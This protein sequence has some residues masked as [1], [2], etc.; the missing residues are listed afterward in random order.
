[1]LGV[2]SRLVDQIHKAWSAGGG[3]RKERRWNKTLATT[4]GILDLIQDLAEQC[5]E[6]G[7]G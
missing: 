7:D 3:S 6:R 2:A 4:S 1:M 5:M